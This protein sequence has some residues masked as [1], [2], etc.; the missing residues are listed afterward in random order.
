MQLWS[1]F[2]TL[3]MLGVIFDIYRSNKDIEILYKRTDKRLKEFEAERQLRVSLQKRIAQLEHRLRQIEGTV[4]DL[5]KV[6]LDIETI[7]PK[8]PGKVTL[9]YVNP[10]E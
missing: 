2:L 4:R 7:L 8:E 6:I 5:P 9:R 10:Q 1:F 3:L